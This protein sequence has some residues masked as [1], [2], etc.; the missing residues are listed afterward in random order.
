MTGIRDY[1]LDG[2]MAGGVP[3][4]SKQLL[5]NA[6]NFS[7]IGFDVTGNE[8]HADGEIWNAVNFRT[9]GPADRQVQEGLPVRR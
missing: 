7:D 8:V 2:D 5:I 6:L 3:E 1:A 9:R 4:Q